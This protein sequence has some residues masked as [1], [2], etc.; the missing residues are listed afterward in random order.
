MRLAGMA[1]AAGDNNDACPVRDAYYEDVLSGRMGIVGGK[2]RAHAAMVASELAPLP[3]PSSALP[4]SSLP[5]LWEACSKD[6]GSRS[7]VSPVE[8]AGSLCRVVSRGGGRGGW[9]YDGSGLRLGLQ[10]AQMHLRRPQRK[11]GGSAWAGACARIRANYV[12]SGF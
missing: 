10:A 7:N 11:T 5:M 4:L 8:E 9:T 2:K 6:G 12:A 1:V 3:R